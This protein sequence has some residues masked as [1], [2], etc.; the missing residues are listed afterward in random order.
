[1]RAFVLIGIA[2]ALTIHSA[3]GDTPLPPPSKITA[4]SP[5]GHIRAISDPKSGTWVEDSKQHKVLW[6]LPDW[7]RAFSSRSGVKA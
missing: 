5:N 1:M 6:R 7:H 3:R 4:T 2:I